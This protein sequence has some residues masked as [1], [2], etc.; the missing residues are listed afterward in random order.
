MSSSRLFARGLPPA[1]DQHSAGKGRIL[2]GL[3]VVTLLSVLPCTVLWWPVY[4]SATFGNLTLLDCVLLALW[5]TTLALF[6]SSHTRFPSL[7]RRCASVCAF[8][9]LIGCCSAVS[10]VVFGRTAYLVDDLLRFMKVFGLPSIIPLSICLMPRY[11]IHRLLTVSALLATTFNIGVQFTDYQDKLPLFSHFSGLSAGQSFR[12]TGAISNPNDYAYI[13]IAGLAFAMAWWTYARRSSVLSRL[14]CFGAIAA[15]S[16]AIVTSG[17]RSAM[18]GL[19][20]GAIYYMSKRGFSVAAKI[21]LATALVFIVVAGWQLSEVFRERMDAAITQR[22]QE[23]NVVSRAEAQ[24]ISLKTWIEWPLGV[25]F[26]NMPE[27]TTPNANGATWVT[28]VQGSDSIYVNFLL[29][30]GIQGFAFLLLCFAGCWKLATMAPLGPRTGVFRSAILCLMFCGFATI[31]PATI[32]VAPFFFTLVGFA[33]L[34]ER[35]DKVS[36]NR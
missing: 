5:I 4:S 6:F 15:T 30:A 34:P 25:G 7:V 24:A 8:A 31:A 12:P 27:A 13:S 9:V 11:P 16:F 35:R 22:S 10:T 19:L 3:H 17:S 28:A 2:E 14:L 18:A 1:T 33:A 20:C 23:M 29:G 21:G 36:R 32:F 26:S